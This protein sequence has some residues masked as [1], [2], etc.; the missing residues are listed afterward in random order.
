MSDTSQRP[1]LW[2][3]NGTVSAIVLMLAVLGSCLI[4]DKWVPNSQ[5][6]LPLLASTITAALTSAIGIPWLRKLK[7]GQVIRTEGPSGH[8][9]KAG[10]PTMG[11]LLVV[12]VGVILGSWISVEGT[13][14]V[15][16]IA[17]SS[18]TLAFMVI[19]GFDDWSSLTK[20]TNTGLTPRGKLLLQGMAAV[21]FLAVAG[22]QGWISSSVSL[23]F[24]W[25]LPLGL[26]IWPLGLFVFLAESNATNLTDGLDGLASG[27]GALV[28]SGLA[29]QLMLRG[30][31][32]D[33]ALAGFCMTM[34]GAWLGFLMHNR[35]PARAFMG[36]TGSLAMGAAL[37]A[38]ALLS[39]SLW[40]LLLMGGV[41]LA[42]SLSVI[43]QV[44]VFKATKGADGQG[45]RILRMAPLHHHFELGGTSER[46]VVPCFWLVTAGCVLLGLLLRPMS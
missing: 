41:F 42:E 38:V 16:L 7:M 6:T 27:C 9:A 34:A 8:Q 3:E 11:G 10:T 46:T 17:V 24:G 29:L 45:R 30:H 19:G 23:P 20:Q 25:S 15:Q 31:S 37:S 21:G 43:V 12:P 14:A 32:G 22:W 28:F 26:A 13:A 18:I 33:P 36:D 35:H 39:D 40:P 44:W 4:S 2:W 5:L 1:L